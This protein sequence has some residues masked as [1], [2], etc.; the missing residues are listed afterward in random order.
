VI[1]IREDTMDQINNCLKEL[2]VTTSLLNLARYMQ[3]GDTNCLWHSIAVAYYSLFLV[4]L[5]RIPCNLHSMLIGA[6]FHDYFLYD[7]HDKDPSHRFH[8]FRHPGTALRNIR[9]IREL[10]P[11]EIDIISKHMFPLTPIP[12]V[13]RESV[14]VCIVDKCCSIY[15]VFCR[16]TYKSLKSRCI[17][18]EA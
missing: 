11:I 1:I 13:Y 17:I 8:G 15:E 18:T 12:P 7:W 9:K 2:M 10:N 3:H 6:L 5:L 4:R 14:I 16:N